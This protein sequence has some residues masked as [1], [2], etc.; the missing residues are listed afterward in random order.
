M[1]RSILILDE[2][3]NNFRVAKPYSL[4]LIWERA[5]DQLPDPFLLF[6]TKEEKID[7]DTYPELLT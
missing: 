6:G 3:Q 1:N 4:A 5:W 2:E 7:R